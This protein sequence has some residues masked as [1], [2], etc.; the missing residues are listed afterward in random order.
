MPIPPTAAKTIRDQ[1]LDVEDAVLLGIKVANGFAIDVKKV[2]QNHESIADKILEYPSLRRVDQGDKFQRRV[3]FM[4]E[5]FISVAVWAYLKDYDRDE[6][7]V[8][9]RQL[10]GD[11]L[12]ALQKDEFCQGMAFETRWQTADPRLNDASQ[13]DQVAVCVGEVGYRVKLDDPYTIWTF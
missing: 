6:G 10:Q 7:R 4:Y 2:Y 13:P 12:K 1:I 11:S 8:L 9:L 5:A 3:G